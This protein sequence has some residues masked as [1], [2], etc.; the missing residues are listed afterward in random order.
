[1]PAVCSSCAAPFADPTVESINSTC[2]CITLEAGAIKRALAGQLVS[3]DVFR[4]IEERCPHLFSAR[5]VFISATQVERMREL[6]GAIE[7]V[8]ALPAYRERILAASAPIAQHTPGAVSGVFFGYDFH[9]HDKGIGLIEINTNAG[10]A[11]LNTALARA[12]HACCDS[13]D[14]TLNSMEAAQ[15]FEDRIVHMFRTEWQRSGRSGELATIAIVDVSPQDQYLYPEFLLF[16]QLLKRHGFGAPICDPAGLQWDNGALYHENLQIDLVYNRLTDFSLAD[17]ASAALRAAYLANA[18]V[19]T[20]HPQA[21]ALY[22]DKRNL[23]ML[24]DP[25]QLTSLGVPVPIQGVL[26]E[27]VPVTRTVNSA[28]A[29]HL[30]KE[31]RNLFFKPAVGYGGRAAY[32]G[33]KLTKRAWVD[34]LSGEYIAQ[35]I[36]PPGRR[37]GGSAEA[38][39]MLKFDVRCYTY[40]GQI[41]WMAARVYQGQTTNFRTPGGGFAP[42]YQLEPAIGTPNTQYLSKF[43]KY[44]PI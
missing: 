4:L 30:W 36:V 37:V 7:S 5:P 24:S 44:Q 13:M 31:R 28:N 6:I 15:L 39:D 27:S 2:F 33:D 22:A 42:V 10:G 40:D 32:R 43:V 12:Q 41:Q 29:D 21:H 34:I 25:T 1:M 17:P 35:D 9:V 23:V 20:P 16:Q 26:L 3:P 11:L 18:V 8:I 14:G 38:P 19:V